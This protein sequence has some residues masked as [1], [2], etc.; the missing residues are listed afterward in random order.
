MKT[1]TLIKKAIKAVSIVETSPTS[2]EVYHP[3]AYDL[4][5]HASAVQNYTTYSAALD[6]AASAVCCVVLKALGATD[7]E[8]DYIASLALPD[9]RYFNHVS[10]DERFFYKAA[11]KAFY[12][13]GP[14]EV[15]AA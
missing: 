10:D 15:E 3:Y 9:Q 8:A 7:D 4:D 5:C 11:K 2:Y 6:A 1:Q 14:V 12:L 13:L